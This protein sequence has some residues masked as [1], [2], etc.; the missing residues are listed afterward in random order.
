MSNIKLQF[1]GYGYSNP[2]NPNNVSQISCYQ[3]GALGE[4]IEMECGV[5]I[6]QCLKI[7]SPA[8]GTYTYSCG[9]TNGTN[10]CD[11]KMWR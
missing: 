1:L 6:D 8:T 4:L 2:N 10:G 7:Y 3:G 11:W 5:N 9:I